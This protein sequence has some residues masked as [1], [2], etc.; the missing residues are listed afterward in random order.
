MNANEH[1]PVEDLVMF[2]LRG[3]PEEEMAAVG[4]HLD[5]CELCRNELHQVRADLSGYAAG[6]VEPTALPGGARGRFTAALK[7]ER[8]RE[9]SARQGERLLAEEQIPLRQA[10]RKPV[11]ARVLAWTGWAVA[12]AALVVA[13]GIRQDRDALRTS[14]QT[15]T[16]ALTRLEAG[17]ARARRVLGALDDPQAVRVVLTMPKAPKPPSARATYSEKTGALLLQASNLPP[18]GQGKEYELWIIPAN[19]GKPIG[20]G[21]FRPDAAGNGNLLAPSIAGATAAKAFG[22]TAE[23]AGGSPG[24]T[25]PILLVGTP[26]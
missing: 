10:G 8:S 19:G 26:G 9:T 23:P 16:A 13:W 11:S 15:Q 20:V 12:A 17:E 18:L 7:K 22:I 25:L 2:A 24:P 4:A 5:G 3:L 1:I 6:A 14:A 21:T